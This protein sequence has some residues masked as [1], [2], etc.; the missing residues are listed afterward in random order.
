MLDE[1][2]GNRRKSKSTKDQ[3][4]IDK[5][6]LQKAKRRITNFHVAWID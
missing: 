3:F 2:K 6:I 4:L 5:M 1:Q